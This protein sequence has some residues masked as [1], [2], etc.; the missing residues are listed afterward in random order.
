MK[1]ILVGLFFVMLSVVVIPRITYAEPETPAFAPVPTT[2]VLLG[3][4]LAVFAGVTVIRK[5]KK[6]S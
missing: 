2:I 1:R 4:C 3:I 5:L 6:S